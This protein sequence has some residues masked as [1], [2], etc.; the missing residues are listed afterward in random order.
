MYGYNTFVTN[1]YDRRFYPR[2][3][4]LKSVVSLS[5]FMKVEGSECFSSAAFLTTCF[6][7]LTV[8]LSQTKTSENADLRFSLSNQG[9]WPMILLPPL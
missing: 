7:S 1:N 4:I 2:L 3:L 5:L 6:R 8:F 9:R